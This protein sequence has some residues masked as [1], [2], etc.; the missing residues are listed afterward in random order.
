MKGLKTLSGCFIALLLT[1]SIGFSET[2]QSVKITADK[3]NVRQD[4]SIESPVLGSLD[5]EAVVDTMA[6]TEGWYK[7]SYAGSPA[8][9]SAE[10]AEVTEDYILGQITGQQVN[11][12]DMP[13]TEDSNILS[14]LSLADIQVHEKQENWYK[15]TTTDGL[16]GYVFGKYVSIMS[17]ADTETKEE[18]LVLNGD[19]PTDLINIA[20]SKLGSPYVW[21]G[22][23]PDS[24]DCSGFI[25]YLYKEAYGINL[26]HS[27]SSISLKGTRIP[28]DQLQVGDLVFFTTNRSGNVNHVGIYLGNNEFIHASSSSYNGRQ[29]H[30]NPLDKGFYSEVYKWGQRLSVE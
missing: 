21:A 6:L 14:T 16:S 18:A 30:I 20:K 23:G 8:Y 5:Q 1:S 2:Y 26:P 19:Y 27:A 11:L 7:I 17:G 28:K 9:I 22:E 15:V 3:L 10:Y 4:M 13:S 25:K 24:F 12:R 29:V